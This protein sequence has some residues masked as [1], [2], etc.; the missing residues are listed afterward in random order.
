MVTKSE[1]FHS[2]FQRV[3]RKGSHYSCSFS[4]MKTLTVLWGEQYIMTISNVSFIT[5]TL[6]IQRIWFFLIPQIVHFDLTLAINSIQHTIRQHFYFHVYIKFI[7]WELKP[8]ERMYV[9]LHWACI[10]FR[11]IKYNR[12]RCSFL[13]NE[14]H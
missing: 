11:N 1:H 2:K 4:W 9:A 14:V 3:L 13:K 10:M 12:S 7:L 6:E 8:T 5:N